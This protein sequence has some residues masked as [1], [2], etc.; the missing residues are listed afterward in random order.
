MHLFLEFLPSS[1]MTEKY[2]YEFCNN[3]SCQVFFRTFGRIN[4]TKLYFH[5]ALML[6]P[7]VKLPYTF[8]IKVDY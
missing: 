5:N 7:D 4:E 6:Q 2:R 8:I 3:Y 1:K